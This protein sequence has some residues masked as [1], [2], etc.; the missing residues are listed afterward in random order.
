VYFSERPRAFSTGYFAAFFRIIASRDEQTGEPEHAHSVTWAL[1][2]AAG[3]RYFPTSRV[4]EKS[5][6]MGLERMDNGRGAKDDRLDARVLEVVSH[7]ASNGKPIAAI[8]H[9]LQ[10]LA[11]AGILSGRSC[12][13][14]PACGPEVKLAGGEYVETPIDGVHVDGNLVTAPA[15]PAHPA[16]L[17]KVLEVLG[18]KIEL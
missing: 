5:P 8:C 3:E 15:W 12:T 10:L 9:G 18:T 17:A 2:D 6:R 16:W 13:A 1:T 7:F 4:S 14:Y 11:A